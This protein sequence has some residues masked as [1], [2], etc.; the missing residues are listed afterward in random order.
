LIARKGRNMRYY[1]LTSLV[2]RNKVTYVR[3]D[4]DQNS[5]FEE[6][7]DY[8]EWESGSIRNKDEWDVMLKI[9]K[10]AAYIA[11]KGNN[12]GGG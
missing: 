11:D 8:G 3:C 1:S 12:R 5:G 9:Q 4:D 2:V 6:P 7:S 10:N